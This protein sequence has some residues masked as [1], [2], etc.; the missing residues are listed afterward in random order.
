MAR[1]LIVDDDRHT[2]ELLRYILEKAAHEIMTACDGA[3]AAKLL[4]TERFDLV[5]TDIYMPE[6]DGFDVMRDVRGLQPDV[7]IVIFTGQRDLHF[8]PLKMAERLGATLVM[9]K[10][11]V[12][13]TVLS[14]VEQALHGPR[15]MAESGT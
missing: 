8:D 6:R 2:C 13:A 9:R 1:I 7:P 3:E 11:I 15:P 5:M 10:P 4:G 14:A 12:P